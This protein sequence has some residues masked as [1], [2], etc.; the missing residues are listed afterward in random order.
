MKIYLRSY[1]DSLKQ[2]GSL[3]IPGRINNIKSPNLVE[4]ASLKVLVSLL[5]QNRNNL[6]LKDRQHLLPAN[7]ELGLQNVC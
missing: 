5:L 1:H 4:E 6:R 7:P 3:L 2:Q